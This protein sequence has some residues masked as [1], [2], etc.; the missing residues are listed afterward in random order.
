MRRTL[1]AIAVAL[2]IG[3]SA[4]YAVQDAEKHVFVTVLDK[5]GAPIQGLTSDFFAVRESGRDRPVVRVEPLRTPMHVAVLVDTGA[6]SGPNEP[7]RAAVVDFIERLGTFNQVGVY[8]FGGRTA[9]V[10]PFT[11]DAGQRRN[12]LNTMFTW[13]HERSHLLDALDMAL[14]DFE[15]IESP[16]PVIVAIASE[17]PEGSRTSAGSVLK[18]IANQSV[19]FHSVVLAAA[20]G[21]VA[22]PSSNIPESSARMTGLMALGQGE[23]ER[24]KLLAQGAATSGGSQQRLSSIMAL[25]PALARLQ[26]ELSNSYKV[27]FTRAGSDR[28]KDLQVGIMLEGVTLRATAAPFG[29][30]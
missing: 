20:A 6:V 4:G 24:S 21:G 8:T 18:R 30:R 25:A 3:S 19:A 2:L 17:N 7:F 13:P 11:H 1:T 26:N 9:A 15:K 29:T 14:K 27:T 5:E 23:R 12:T 22:A 16:R 28:I 10:L